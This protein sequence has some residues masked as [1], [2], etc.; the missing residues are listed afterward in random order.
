[1]NT[2]LL[3]IG[4]GPFGLAMAAHAKH[5]GIDFIMVGKPME[6]WKMNMPEGMYLRSA[7]DW[8]LD[9]KN[10]H[11]IERFLSTQHLAPADVE[12][13]SRNFYLSY[14]E[15][16]QKQK[17]ITALP[18]YVDR[19]DY[20]D[21]YKYYAVTDEG[22]IITANNVVIALGFKYF[23]HIPPEFE[24]IFP[25]DACS[26]TCDLTDMKSMQYKR[27]LILGGRQSAFEWAALLAEAGAETIYIS[28]RHKSPE[29]MAS[30]WSW[31]N[32]IVDNIV[33]EPGW[34]RNLAAEE[35]DL[36]SKKLWE[37]GRLKIEPWLEKRVMK[38]NVKLLPYTEIIAGKKLPKGEL[39]VAFNN[40]VTITVDHIIFATGYKA[41]ISKVPL[42]ARGNI[43]SKLAI[44]NNFPVLNEY[45]QTNMPGLFITSMPA[46][47]DFGP[48]FGFTIAV[49]TSAKLIGEAL[50]MLSQ[51]NMQPVS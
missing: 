8:H 46:S 34:F 42:L 28:H 15:W 7:C 16:F 26:H 38:D 3:I 22:D 11:T 4:A 17:Q 2:N 27:C 31:V 35:K 1:M 48:F 6:F 47:Q 23:K 45:F 37:E 30:D 40:G 5:L 24:N 32:P 12:P 21:N 44:Q 19:L 41:V 49:R 13:L 50:N 36:L 33:H 25:Q 10:E 43:L 51:K 29:F 14:T 39:E 9:P 18:V 20:A